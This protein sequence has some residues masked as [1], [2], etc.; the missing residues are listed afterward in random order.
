MIGSLF[1]AAVVDRIGIKKAA[2]IGSLF[3]SSTVFSQMLPAW[4]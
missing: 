2:V 3:L 4:R 1:G